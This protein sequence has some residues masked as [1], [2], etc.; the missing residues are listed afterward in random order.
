MY[1]ENG[2]LEYETLEY[3]TLV[4]TPGLG[5][6]FDN[7]LLSLQ[8]LLLLQGIQQGRGGMR[9]G[10]ERRR[11]GGGHISCQ[12]QHRRTKKKIARKHV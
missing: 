3:E 9:E 4:Y 12:L 7:I 8:H 5:T 11:S 10:E 2:L 1:G 6:L